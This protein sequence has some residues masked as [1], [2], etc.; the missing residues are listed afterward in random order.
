MNW[1]AI[2]ATGEVLGAIAV[3]VSLVYLA[4]QIRQN[5]R[6]IDENTKAAQAAAFDSSIAHTF[7]ARQAIAENS[8]VARIYLDGSNDPDSL[9]EEDRVRY[10]LIVH[11]ILWSLWNIQSQS[12]VGGELAS[13]TWS[14]Q[15]A[16]LK[17]MMS[18]RGFR[19]FWGNYSQEFGASFQKIVDDLEGKSR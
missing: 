19:W 11:N 8:D 3:V 1:D 15:L 16:I 13:E 14:A 12:Q 4:F 10:R 18:T 5:T 6:Q 7:K 9:S 2:G 17:R